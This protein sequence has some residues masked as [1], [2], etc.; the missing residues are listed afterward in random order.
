[1]WSVN[2]NKRRGQ[3]IFK[4]SASRRDVGA[5]TCGGR[6]VVAGGKDGNVDVFNSSS[7]TDGERITYKLGKAISS[8]RIACVGKRIALI[9]GGNQNQVFVVDTAA[10]P[11]KGATLAQAPLPLSG[12]GRV[13]VA[14]DTASGLVMFFDGQHADLF[15]IAGED[16]VST[17]IV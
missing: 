4:M 15:S 17:I 3:P 16:E 6:L 14:A 5:S 9:S 2:P 11:A 13:A 10:L 8:P 1:M 12:G 7:I